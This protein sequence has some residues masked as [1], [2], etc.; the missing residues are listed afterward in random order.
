MRTKRELGEPFRTKTASRRES[1]QRT[2]GIERR[3]P[4]NAKFR[5][6]TFFGSQGFRGTEIKSQGAIMA[7]QAVHPELKVTGRADD[8]ARRVSPPQSASSGDDSDEWPLLTL[9]LN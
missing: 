6:G 1:E 5:R 9:R 2:S 8:E 3:S 7:E 4:R